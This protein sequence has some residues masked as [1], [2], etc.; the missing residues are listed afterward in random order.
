MAILKKIQ[1]ARDALKIDKTGYDDRNDFYYFKADDVAAGVR[2]A[3]TS[4]G[5]I[6]RTEVV[7]LDIDNFWDSN[8][9]NRH[10]VTGHFRVTFVDPDDGSEFSTDA[11]A[12]GSDIGGDKATRKAAVQAFKI[13]AIDVFT[14]AEGMQSMDSDSY[15]EAEPIAKSA[16]PTESAE[17]TS[18]ELGDELTK[19]MNDPEHEHITGEVIAKVGQRVADEILGEGVKLPVWKKDA[20]VLAPLI[21]RLKKGEVG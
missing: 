14:I 10:R 20:R 18:K 19:L 15:A 7:N 2:K 3:F 1:E 6:H 16:E 8:G 17:K 21:D 4:H 11:I 9:R 5:I 13:A 12:T